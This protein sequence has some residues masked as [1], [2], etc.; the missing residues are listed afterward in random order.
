MGAGLFV[1]SLRYLRHLDSGFVAEHVLV[2]NI[3]APRQYPA[4]QLLG[5]AEALRAQA[6][7]FPGVRAAGLSHIRPLSGFAITGKVDA[8]GYVPQPHEDTDV[9]DLSISP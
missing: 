4:S 7:A 2:A 6:A 3:G 9:D 8:E 5:R 1:R